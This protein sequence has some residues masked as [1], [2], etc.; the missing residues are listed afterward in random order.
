LQRRVAG[1]QAPFLDTFNFIAGQTPH[2]SLPAVPLHPS[3]LAL[4]YQLGNLY[5]LLGMCGVAVIYGTSEP[6]VLRN[7]LIALAIAD[8]GHLYATYLA[9]GYV[10]FVDYASWGQVAWGNIAATVFL[11]VN[12]ILYLVGAFGCAQAPVKDEKKIV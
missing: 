3:T 4:N 11:F 6:H 1:F 7:Y 5:L 9:M 8:I 2:A 10:S 12:R